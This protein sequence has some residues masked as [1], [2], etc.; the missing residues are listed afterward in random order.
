VSWGKDF[1]GGGPAVA[2]FNKGAP[3]YLNRTVRVKCWADGKLQAPLSPLRQNF[4]KQLGRPISHPRLGVDEKGRLW[5]LFR[6]ATNPDGSQENWSS[7][8]VVYD[9]EQ[10]SAPLLIANSVNI[11]DVRPTLA[12]AH[13]I[14][15]A[16]YASDKRPAGTG[17]RSDSDLFAVMLSLPGKTKAGQIDSYRSR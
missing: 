3:L 17:S 2:P 4:P 14:L 5:L 10:W 1:A 11:M 9:G 16:F 15:L 6:H 8:A 7:Y 13:S 12:L